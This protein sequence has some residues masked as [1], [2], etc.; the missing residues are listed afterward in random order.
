MH[1]Y[2]KNLN[3]QDDQI[4]HGAV[5]IYVENFVSS[6]RMEL[7]T[8]LQAV[9]VSIKI[10]KHITVCSL[11]LPPGEKIRKEQLQELIDQLLKPF[12]ILGDMNAHHPMWYDPRNIDRRGEIIV[13][14]I[15]E[16]DLALLDQNKMTSIWKVDKSFSHIDL[17]IF[18]RT[19][20]MV[21]VGCL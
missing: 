10:R 16:N 3:I 18:R 6:Y 19:A 2:Q 1:T 14:L 4:P 12:L 7:E 8:T 20:Y 15:A 11:Y 5:A 21:P 9:A 13:D 17:Y